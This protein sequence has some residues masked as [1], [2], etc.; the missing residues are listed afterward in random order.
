MRVAMLIQGYYPLIGGA[1]VFAQEVAEHLVK[2]GHDVDIITTRLDRSLREV[3][4]LNGV[5]VHRIALGGVKYLSFVAG[6]FRLLWHVLRLDRTR[7]YDF[8]HAVSDGLPSLVAATAKKLR[9]KP[10]LITIQGGTITPD[11]RKNLSGRIAAKL[12]QWSFRNADAV[13]VISRKLREQAKQ[14]SARNPI[15]IPN[16]VDASIFRP[17]NKSGLRKTH[18]FSQDENIIIGVARLIPRKGIDYLIRA[19]AKVAEHLPN[20]RLLIIGDGIQRA[21]LE[22]L[23]LKAGLG[24]KAQILGLVSHEQVPQYL[25]MADVFV[26]PSLFEPLGIVT[27]EAMACGI[28]VIGTNVDGI[29][30]I[31]EDGKNG[32]LV[33][34][35]DDEQIAEALMTLL[36]DEDTRNKLA[37][38]GLE[39]VKQKFLWETVLMRIEDLYSALLDPVKEAS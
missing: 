12:Q 8:I 23:I 3:E 9:G 18:G 17:M 4:T 20:L 35:G 22:K 27:I 19:T 10:Y 30:D 29:P 15:V 2:K 16:G 14:L 21:N 34:P 5:V 6:Y 24:N 39:T 13:H 36:S 37:Q 25:N 32:I 26:I 11:Y 28:P 33:P 7:D 1:E 38:E 31:V